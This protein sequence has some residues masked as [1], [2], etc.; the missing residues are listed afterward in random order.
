MALGPALSVMWGSGVI[1]VVWW[2]IRRRRVVRLRRRSPSGCPIGLGRRSL[3]R[4]LLRCRRRCR[5]LVGRAV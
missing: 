4:G 3:R 1:V 2:G 5:W